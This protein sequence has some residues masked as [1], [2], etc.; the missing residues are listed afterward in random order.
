MGERGQRAGQ[1]ATETDKY[2]FLCLHIVLY[3]LLNI[4]CEFITHEEINIKVNVFVSV[5]WKNKTAYKLPPC[6]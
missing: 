4:N 1:P 3:H 6:Y 2:I 5:D